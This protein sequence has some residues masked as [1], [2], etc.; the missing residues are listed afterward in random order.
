MIHDYHES[1]LT[2]IGSGPVALYITSQVNCKFLALALLALKTE[3]CLVCL[4]TIVFFSRCTLTKLNCCKTACDINWISHKM[5]K[6]GSAC[7]GRLLAPDLPIAVDFWKVP[8]SKDKFKV[9][10]NMFE[11]LI[12][13]QDTNFSFFFRHTC[14]FSHTCTRIIQKV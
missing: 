14:T 7:N 10:R 4:F 3:N 6:K 1:R 2:L 11:T 12:C 9:R 13:L 5:E 8:E